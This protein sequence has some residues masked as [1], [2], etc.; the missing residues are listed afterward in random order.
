MRVCACVNRPLYIYVCVCVCVRVWFEFVYSYE[1][2][3][4]VSSI[5]LFVGLFIIIITCMH[6]YIGIYTHKH[7]QIA[8]S[9]LLMFMCKWISPS[10]SNGACRCCTR[11]LKA[12]QSAEPQD[13]AWS[14]SNP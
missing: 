10:L 6:F 1:L 4:Y 2:H 3:I 13:V 11:E 12:S 8:I 5:L 7:V 9:G 14:P